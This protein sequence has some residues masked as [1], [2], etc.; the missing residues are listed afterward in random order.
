MRSEDFELLYDLEEN[1]WWFVAM[2]TI[3]DAVVASDL[4]K[5]ELKILDAGCGTGFNLGY[6][7]SQAGRD[8]YGLD[9]AP[10]ALHGV[11]K[12]GF[13]K[14]VQASVTGIPFQTGT[15]DLVFS[16]DVM[17]Q[18]SPKLSGSAF[19]EMFRVLRPGGSLFI[20]VAAFEWLRSSHDEEIR[21]AHRFTRGELIGKLVQAGFKTEYAT[22][23]NGLLFPVIVARRLLKH[24]GLGKGTDVKPLPAGLRWVDPIFRRILSKEAALFRVGKTLP[25][26]LS[27]IACARK[28]QGQVNSFH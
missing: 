12:R 5:P 1:Y 9:I 23:A 10:E 15:F 3:T 13:H 21:T 24:L 7:Q 14:I 22:Y 25:F 6:Y 19:K 26:G 11:R 8:V 2:R 27:V 4:R 17:Q 20:R 16:F 18:V 28:P